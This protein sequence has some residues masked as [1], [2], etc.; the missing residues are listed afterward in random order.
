MY[1]TERTQKN[2]RSFETMNPAITQFYQENPSIDFEEVN[3]FFIKFMTNMKSNSRHDAQA[4]EPKVLFKEMTSLCTSYCQGELGDKKLE[5]ILNEMY[6][7][8]EINNTELEFT[9]KRENKSTIVFENKVSEKNI[10]VEDTKHFFK[11]I[12]S[13]N[14]H[15]IF[16]SQNS[17]IISKSN[18]MI[19]INNGNILVY[20]HNVNYDAS[21]IKVAIDIIDNLSSKLSD[22]Y[23]PIKNDCN[24]QKKILDEINKEYQ[25]FRAQKELTINFIKENNKTLLNQLADLEF[26]CLDKYLSSKYNN[27]AKPGIITCNLCNCYTS[28]TL[29]GM[30]AHKRGCVKKQPSK[31]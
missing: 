28:Y 30:A 12:N 15:G 9:M 1:G 14:S 29:K 13:L 5:K 2:S 31:A 17:G 24:I 10:G 18:Y 22:V 11:K 7:T 23:L 26:Q 25:L 3:L 8:S 27:V 4:V 20:V 21:K 19:D 16:I 6:P